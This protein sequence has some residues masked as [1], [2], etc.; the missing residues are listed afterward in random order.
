MRDSFEYRLNVMG[1]QDKNIRIQNH[2]RKF[3]LNSHQESFAFIALRS[4]CE[5]LLQRLVR[6]KEVKRW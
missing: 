5:E 3:L 2:N 4:A 1:I 6:T